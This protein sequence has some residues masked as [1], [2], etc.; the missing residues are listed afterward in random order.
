LPGGITEV[1]LCSKTFRHL[2]IWTVA[3]G[4]LRGSP[5]LRVDDVCL[6]GAFGD[7][8]AVIE[9]KRGFCGEELPRLFHQPGGDHHRYTDGRWLPEPELRLR[10]DALCLGE[11]GVRHSLVEDGA[12]DTA[13]DEPVPALVELADG[14]LASGLVAFLFEVELEPD[15]VVPAAGETTGE[16]LLGGIYRRQLLLPAQHLRLLSRGGYYSETRMS[17]SSPGVENIGEWLVSMEMT[18]HGRAVYICFCT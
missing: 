3:A 17:T 10:S 14:E 15:G 11:V 7:N 13:V 4:A 16:Q 18:L 1:L 12:Y 2:N 5:L 6:G 9:G 8:S